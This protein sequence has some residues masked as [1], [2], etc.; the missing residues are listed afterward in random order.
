MFLQPWLF[1]CHCF[2]QCRQKL[3]K[4]GRCFGSVNMSEHTE[5][6]TSS[7]RLWSNVV[8]SMSSLETG[9]QI[10]VFTEYNCKQCSLMLFLALLRILA[11]YYDNPFHY[12]NQPGLLFLVDFL[13]F[14]IP[15]NVIKAHPVSLTDLQKPLFLL[16][17][18]KLFYFSQ[19]RKRLSP[20]SGNLIF[21]LSI[22]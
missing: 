10:K 1:V 22:T 21:E 16:R 14:L 17:L 5:Q 8:M 18:L 13:R 4:H 2:K 19:W 11:L 7:R 6:D 3:C 9:K 15:R 20:K 12:T